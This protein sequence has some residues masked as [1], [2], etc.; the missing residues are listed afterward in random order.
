MDLIFSFRPSS[1]AG[2]AALLKYI[3]TLEDWQMAPGLEDGDSMKAVKTLCTC[4]A[5]AIEQSG[6]RA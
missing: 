6:V 1:V 2:V 4:L 5:A 3:S